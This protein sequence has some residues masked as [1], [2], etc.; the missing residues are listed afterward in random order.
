[1]KNIN[2]I[3]KNKGAA[4][5][6]LVFFFMF[7][8]LTILI[9]IVT[10]VVREFK[11]ATDNFASKKSYFTAESGMED[12]MYRIKNNMDF[13]ASENLI[14]DDSS[15]VTTITDISSSQKEIISLG[16]TNFIQR[17]IKTIVNIGVG[18]SFSYGILTGEGG[19]SMN[20]GSK[21]IGSV[22][23]N[24]AITGSGSITGSA[25]SANS[26]ALT[27][28]QS[29]GVGVPDYDITFG[30]TNGTQDY[31][32]SFQV[33]TTGVINKVQLYL[34]KVGSPSNI[35]VRIVSDSGGVPST[36]VL[37]TATLSASAVSTNYGWVDVSFFSNPQLSSSMIY[38][39]VLDSVTSSS[40]YYKIGANNNGY[41]NG[42]NKIGQY[43]STWNNTLPSELDGFFSLYLGG[44]TGSIDGI[45]VGTL[46]VGNAY[47]HTVEN[48]N[49]AGINYC[50]TGSGNNKACDT[51]RED[52]VPVGMPISEQNI[53]DW[54][55]SAEAGGVISGNYTVPSN[56]T[57]GPKK[58]TGNLILENGKTLTLGGTIWVQGN[59]TADNNAIIKLS[60]GYGASSGVIVV[61]GTINISNNSTFSGSG[62]VG[63][64]IFVL[65]T[66]SSTSA[67]NLSNNAGAV[68]LYAAN[69]TINVNNNG[70]AK[71]LTGYNIHLGNNAIITYDSGLAN[72]NF[73]SGPSGS[74]NIY[75]WKETE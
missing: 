6:T 57:L 75:S 69:G 37:T 29:N 27:S 62:T 74:W 23:S 8:S 22:Y 63:S 60:S 21:I 73:V 24:G 41:A 2:T 11:I 3:Q 33:G 16:D 7:I 25:T 72:T 70:T 32:Q 68:S 42:V 52:P 14:I 53:L 9:G 34:K 5:I 38:W 50:K 4:M 13:G 61:D 64:Y 43:S 47:A 55:D 58:I 40:N 51:S 31:A 44:L 28:D 67:I 56:M 45:S 46:S 1:M 36:T 48:S 65:S 12:V 17:K 71:S 35:T 26:P 20:N 19:F 15:T 18:A 54:K 10:P 30:N 39:L 59:F 66:S 49:I